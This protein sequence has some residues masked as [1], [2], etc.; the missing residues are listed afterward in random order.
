MDN[1]VKKVAAVLHH[2]TIRLE[3]DSDRA[4]VHIIWVGAAVGWA[5]CEH[6]SISIAFVVVDDRFKPFALL[7]EL[8][9]EFLE[10]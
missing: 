4:T 6:R 2:G 8:F 7:G 5:L 3:L 1:R 10:R 9:L